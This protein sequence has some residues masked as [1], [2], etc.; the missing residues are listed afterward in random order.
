MLNPCG[1]TSN[2][3]LIKPLL[4]DEQLVS[5]QTI[6]GL[7]GRQTWI[8]QGVTNVDRWNKEQ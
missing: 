3:G 5:D 2:W 4:T 6:G 7:I 8:Y 1:R